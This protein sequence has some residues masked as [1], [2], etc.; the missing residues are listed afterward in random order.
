MNYLAFWEW[1]GKREAEPF[2]FFLMKKQLEPY[3][4]NMSSFVKNN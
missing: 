2:H 3:F 1:E 4:V